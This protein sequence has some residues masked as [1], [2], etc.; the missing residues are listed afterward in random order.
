MVRIADTPQELLASRHHAVAQWFNAALKV[1][2]EQDVARMLAAIVGDSHFQD[3]TALGLAAKYNHDKIAAQLLTEAPSLA[4]ETNQFGQNV[5]DIAA[6]NGK[7]KVVAVLLAR[8]PHL[9]KKGQ[10]PNGR[11]A[12]HSACRDGRTKIVAQFL[13][14][15]PNLSNQV[16]SSGWTGLH[17][18]AFNGQEGVVDLLLRVNPRLMCPVGEGE[19]V[20]HLACKSHS[21]SKL[22]Y[23]KLLAL[24]PKALR[25]A[26]NFSATPFELALRER[27]DC[28]I[29]VMIWQL[30][31]DEIT[32]VFTANSRHNYEG[33]LRQIMER[34]CACLAKSL[35]NRDVAGIVFEY[36]GFFNRVPQKFPRSR[37]EVLLSWLRR[38][39]N[40]RFPCG[41][42]ELDQPQPAAGQILFSRAQKNAQC[43]GEISSR[44]NSSLPENCRRHPPWEASSSGKHSLANNTKHNKQRNP[45][46][47]NHRQHPRYFTNTSRSHR[48]C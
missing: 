5:L 1:H 41:S 12:L 20:L 38:T 32:S 7:D 45:T 39:E 8:C 25:T 37:M 48:G 17:Y 46:N 9:I 33:R 31:F 2:N 28:A 21:Q 24:N 15:S 10:P 47:M 23:A 29:D 35:L 18:A 40:G 4:N 27:N 11:T 22:F 3:T 36:I 6:A 42:W 19:T 43:A 30:T 34:Q 16:D 44:T 26:S 13:A 14:M